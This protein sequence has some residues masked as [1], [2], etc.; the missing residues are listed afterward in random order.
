[1]STLY[2]NIQVFGSHENVSDQK[3]VTSNSLQSVRSS[4]INR[5][6]NMGSVCVY[7]YMG[8]HPISRFHISWHDAPYLPSNLVIVCDP[9]LVLTI[10]HTWIHIRAIRGELLQVT[11]ERITNFVANSERR[12]MKS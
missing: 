7:M 2:I 6:N 1:M 12:T 9:K 11:V 10:L 3:C 4:D 5:Q 8:S